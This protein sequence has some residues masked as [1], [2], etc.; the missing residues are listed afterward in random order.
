MAEFSTPFVNIRLVRDS[1]FINLR[2]ERVSEWH[3]NAL[4]G[5][6]PYYFRWM[7]YAIG[8]KN[9][10]RYKINGALM[11]LSFFLCRIFAMPFYWYF[12]LKNYNEPQ[13]KM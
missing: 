6:I 13:F 2:V 12:V 3:L 8:L 4:D 10:R 7:L 1:Y 9:T 5:T 11:T